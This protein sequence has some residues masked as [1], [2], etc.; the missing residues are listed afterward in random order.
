[1]VDSTVYF[2]LPSDVR[3]AEVT[4]AE[5]KSLAV[6]FQSSL[7]QRGLPV[8]EI[9]GSEDDLWGFSF[10]FGKYEILF[11]VSPNRLSKPQRWF[12]DVSL[13]DPGWFQATRQG[14]L[15]E[16]KRVE[17]AVHSALVSDLHAKKVTW[18]LGKGRIDRREARSEP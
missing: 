16:L 4:E 8:G 12:A 18:Y 1:M 15:A 6:T 10:D 9:F 11:S 5:L 17:R 13:H 2:D 14:R 3:H 7:R